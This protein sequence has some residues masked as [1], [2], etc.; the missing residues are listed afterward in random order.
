ML[1]A[2]LQHPEFEAYRPTSLKAVT[3]GGAPVPVAV[4]EQVKERMGTDI[5]IVFGQ[6][7]S[8]GGITLTL[9]ESSS[10][11]IVADSHGG[12]IESEFD[13]DTLKLTTNDSHNDSH[14]EGKYG[15][16]RAPKIILKTTYATIAIHK[17]S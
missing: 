9:P 4:M 3:S 16:G 5:A 10:F 1:I 7:E 8:T 13:A 12:D 15:K 17:T 11:E 2:M 14:L 6:T